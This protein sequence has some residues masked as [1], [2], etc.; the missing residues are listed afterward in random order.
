MS[1]RRG[2]LARWIFVVT[3]TLFEAELGIKSRREQHAT[4]DAR[5]GPAD[6]LSDID[7]VGPEERV[8]RSAR[9]HTRA[10]GLPAVQPHA[11]VDRQS[12]LG[13]IVAHS[14]LH[15]EPCLHK[16]PRFLWR[17]RIPESDETRVLLPQAPH[18]VKVR[19]FAHLV[20]CFVEIREDLEVQIRV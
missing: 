9:V 8:P 10:R 11:Q 4:F 2:M 17:R 12:A 16:P 3:L 6:A 15:L 14:R 7:E 18:L 5:R 19:G 13:R 1:C 20:E